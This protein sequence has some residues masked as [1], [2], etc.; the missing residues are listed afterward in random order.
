MT[1]ANF[2]DSGDALLTA[3]AHDMPPPVFAAV[4]GAQFDDLP[5]LLKDAGLS[6]R[7]LFLGVADAESEKAGPWFVDVNMTR[8]MNAFLA[9]VGDQPAAVFWSC[10]AGE[11][12]LYR[13]L[14]MLNEAIVPLPRGDAPE[15]AA[16]A[17]RP[18]SDYRDARVLFRH[19]DPRVLVDVLPVLDEAQFARVLGPAALVMI[20]RE[21]GGAPFTA[22]AVD[23]SLIAPQGPLRMRAEQLDA[24]SDRRAAQSRRRI[25]GYLR[26][27]APDQTGDVDDRR[28]AKMVH[29][30]ETSAG[31][32][33]VRS[34]RAVGLWAYMLATSQNDFTREWTVKR[35]M[36]ATDLDAAPEQRVKMLFDARQRSLAGAR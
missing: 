9:L 7:S 34:E 24:I 21:G 29:Y 5:A 20:P 16:G 11:S 10:P 22:P 19:W 17:A 28:L 3:A 14:R 30:A 32:F 8:S 33:G 6:F 31:A 4:D 1:Q 35:F 12:A 23:A 15:R 26:D 36:T 27:V 13:H 2:S 25:V 18:A